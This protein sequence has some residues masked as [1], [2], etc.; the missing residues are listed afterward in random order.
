MYPHSHSSTQLTAASSGSQLFLS[1]SH[2]FRFKS[3]SEFALEICKAG[4]L[5][6]KCLYQGK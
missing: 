3:T 4:H 5:K 6:K 2:L 1:N